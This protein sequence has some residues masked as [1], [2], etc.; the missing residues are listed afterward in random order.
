MCSYS[1]PPSSSSTP[2]TEINSNLSNIQI[3]NVVNNSV[4]EWI[5]DRKP[6][7]DALKNF[8]STLLSRPT[9]ALSTQTS[10]SAV[11]NP[12]SFAATLIT[13]YLQIDEINV[14]QTSEEETRNV[15]GARKWAKFFGEVPPP[16]K[17]PRQIAEL[18]QGNDLRIDLNNKPKYLLF[19]VPDKIDNEPHNGNLLIVL[20]TNSPTR[21]NKITFSVILDEDQ[22]D[23]LLDFSVRRPY[24]ALLETQGKDI[25]TNP[26]QTEAQIS[27]PP[28]YELPSVLDVLIAKVV[29]FIWRG[30]HMYSPTD[31]T[32][33]VCRNH[34]YSR[35]RFVDCFVSFDITDANERNLYIAATEVVKRRRT[36]DSI[37]R[38]SAVSAVP[39][40]GFNGY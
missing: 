23:S 29:N 33:I 34:Y 38:G 20:A 11:P 37:E 13:D 26:S 9:G 39:F 28:G 30:D 19:Y 24:W 5:A 8:F 15:F 21:S 10:N 40:R 35:R 22:R 16:P 3:T 17:L 36:G 4:A 1:C 7:E 31:N 27:L 32:F 14:D 18:W 6:V 2:Y 12:Y 25:T